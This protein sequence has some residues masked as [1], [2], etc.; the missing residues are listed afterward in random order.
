MARAL[1]DAG[2]RVALTGRDEG[3]L[4]AALATLREGPGDT[5]S[6]PMDVREGAAPPL[7]PDSGGTAAPAS[8]TSV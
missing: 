4:R 6:L 1:V 2:E 3:R 5:L 8:P 7:Q